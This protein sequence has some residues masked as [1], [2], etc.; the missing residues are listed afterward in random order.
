M[1]ISVIEAEHIG[2][3]TKY[4]YDSWRVGLITPAERFEKI[5]YL[6]RHNQTDEIFI[7]LKG[8]AVLIGKN[9]RNEVH[10]IELDNGKLYCVPKTFWHNIRI[11]EHSLVAVIENADTTKENTDYMDYDVNI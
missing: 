6:E 9:D 7:L 5:T 10:T 4:V 1:N 2:Y 3:M 11:Y 8:K